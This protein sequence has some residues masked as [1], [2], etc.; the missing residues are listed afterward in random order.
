[1][2]LLFIRW[3]GSEVAIIPMTD[4]N[5]KKD[6]AASQLHN[7]L[8]IRIMDYLEGKTSL[9]G[10]FRFCETLQE[11]K[12]VVLPKNIIEATT[13]LLNLKREID[14]KKITNDEVIVEVTTIQNGLTSI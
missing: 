2:R 9:E 3:K 13:E 11:Q 12:A 4:E 8:V 10:V 5:T 6:S 7:K 1:M 14:E